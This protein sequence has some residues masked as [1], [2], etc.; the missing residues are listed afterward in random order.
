M[1]TLNNL[2]IASLVTSLI[3]CGGAE[4]R[5]AV[6]M[7]KA[8]RS[9]QSGDYDKARIELKNVL[10]IDPKDAEA[11]FQL[12]KVHEA[13]QEFRKAF[14]NYNKAAELLPDN[15]EYKAKIGRFYLVLAN[16]VT[17]ADEYLKEIEA[18]DSG[19]KYVRLLKAGILYKQNEKQASQSLLE[20]LHQQYPEDVEISK[21]LAQQYSMQKHY[22]KAQ[23]TLQATLQHAPTDTGLLSVLAQSYLLAKDADNAEKT[24][25]KVIE[26]KPESLIYR[27]NLARFYLNQKQD[28]KAEQVMLDAIAQDEDDVDRKLVYLDFVK[29]TKGETAAAEKLDNFIQQKSEPK[30]LLAK[31]ALQLQTGD[32]D[33]AIK[34]YEQIAS[35][36]SEEGAG[37]TA[38]VA[39]S[40]LY[41]MQKDIDKGKQVIAEAQ[42]IAPNDA[43]VNMVVA[44]IAIAEKDYEKAIISLRTVVKDD[45]EN[46]DAYLLLAQ[47]HKANGDVGQHDTVLQNAYENNRGNVKALEKLSAYYARIG[48]ADKTESIAD[49]ILALQADNY[50]AMAMKAA[51]LNR[52]KDYIEGHEMAEKLL[53]MAPAKPQGYIQ[54][55]PYLLAEKRYE[56]TVALLEQGYEK[57]REPSLLSAASDIDLKTGKFDRV[58]SRTQRIDDYAKHESL[59]LQVA[60]AYFG[61]G[62]KK[63]GMQELE[64]SLERDAKRTTTRLALAGAYRAQ[65]QTDASIK[66]LEQGLAFDPDSIKLR[67][68]LA[69]IYEAKGDFEQAISQYESILD[70]SPNNVI[71][72]NNLAA[73]LADHRSDEAGLSRAMELA[74]KIKAMKQPV[75]KDTVGWVYYKNGKYSEAVTVLK[76]VVEAA[77]DVAVYNYHLGMALLD[78]GNLVEAK[79]YLQKAV[80]S[81]TD[82][83]GKA[84]AGKALKSL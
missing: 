75:L 84:E 18:I 82:F 68:T 17:K 44:K 15:V 23:K 11:Y 79:Q 40:K 73:L 29:Q 20:S 47:A 74:D 31:A 37:I 69:G 13:K 55:V 41:I 35:Q 12:G 28:D 2:L 10:Q 70:V 39:L 3:A 49:D 34:T 33:G 67:I 83:N 56:D 54:S 71:A 46:A 14:A 25:K 8:Q 7:E 53:A 6:Y 32:R 60:K 77:P 45:P 19:N 64:N 52:K 38:R 80:D 66:M 5:K 43:E 58:I 48:Q 1:K 9:I 78:S 26:L 22:D 81:G 76:E 21:F 42:T 27:V 51:T 61:K 72:T 62:D 30:L 36:Y 16:D 59:S 24:L 63:A 57:T 65:G 50:Q 4:E